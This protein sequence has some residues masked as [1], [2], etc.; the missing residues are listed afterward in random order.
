MIKSMRNSLL[1]L[2]RWLALAMG[3]LGFHVSAFAQR[4][5]RV[6]D[7]FEYEADSELPRDYQVPGEFV[8]GRL[9]YPSGVRFGRFGGGDWLSGGT[10]WAVDYPRGDRTFARLLRRFTTVN[11]RSVEQPVNPDDGDDMHHWPFLV[12]G[13]AGFWNLT[14][15]QVANLREYLLR[16]GFLFCDSFFG[17]DS[18]IGFDLGIRRIFP[19]R[20]MVDLTDDHPVFHTVYDLSNMTRVQIP[21][22][23]ALYGGGPGYLGDGAVPRWR[24]ILDDNGRLMVLIAFNNDVADSWQWADDPSYPQESANLGL[25]LAVN[26]A[27]YTMTH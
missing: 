8:I 19:D 4:E 21:N 15:A 26:I 25:R 18:W 1:L 9:M 17:T 27:V 23:Y 24:G 3:L 13:L 5:F 7:S 16:G 2:G 10:S 14:D 11:V 20:P 12:A 22:M 6:Y